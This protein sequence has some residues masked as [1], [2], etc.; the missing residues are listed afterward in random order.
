MSGL[1]SCINNI[2]KFITPND[3]YLLE[4]V[5]MKDL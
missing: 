4:I 5:Y 3:Y 2:L 1:H